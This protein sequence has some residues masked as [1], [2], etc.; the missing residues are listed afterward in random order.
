MLHDHKINYNVEK[1]L[2]KNSL[3]FMKKCF[4]NG[5]ASFKN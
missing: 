2:E 3:Q 1:L 4:Y 5:V